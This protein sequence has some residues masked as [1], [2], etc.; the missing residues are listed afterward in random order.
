MLENGLEGVLE[1]IPS[2]LRA[3]LWARS[4]RL[5]RSHRRNEKVWSVGHQTSRIDV[6]ALAKHRCQACVLRQ[7]DDTNSVIVYKRVGTDITSFRAV[8]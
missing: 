2:D 8:L 5:I 6:L 1:R 3:S 4:R 7:T